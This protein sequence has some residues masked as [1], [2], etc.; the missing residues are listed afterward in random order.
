MINRFKVDL[1]ILK[2]VNTQN[3]EIKSMMLTLMEI[4]RRKTNLKDG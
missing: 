4:Y 1:A 3:Q 2:A